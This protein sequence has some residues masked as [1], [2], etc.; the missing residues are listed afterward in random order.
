[1]DWPMFRQVE[2]RAIRLHQMMAHL[3]VD[4]V[5][6]ARLRRGDA[7]A[8]ARTRCLN[9]GTAEKGLRLPE[10]CPNLRDFEKCMKPLPR[11]GEKEFCVEGHADVTG[12]SPSHPTCDRAACDP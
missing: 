1:M 10:F 11:E 3:G 6:F 4:V 5:Q 12:A 8:E 7:Y 9:C 2:R